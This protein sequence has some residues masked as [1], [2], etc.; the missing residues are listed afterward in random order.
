MKVK[1]YT[2]SFF[3]VCFFYLL[4][5]ISGKVEMA[6]WLKPILI[7]FL[8]TIISLSEK[9]KTQKLLQLGLFFSWIG[10]VLLLFTDRNSLF[11]ISGLVA[12]LIAHLVYIL[13]F[14]KQVKIVKS[15]QHIR[16]LPLIL[17]YLFGMI[18]LLWQ[19]LAEM[20]VPVI[21]YA[22]VISAMLLMSVKGYFEWKKPA[23]L[24]ILVGAILFVISDSILAI[25]KFYAPIPLSSFLIMSTY[26]A[27]QYFI[28]KGILN[29]NSV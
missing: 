19:S 17:V 9:F 12:F 16:I 14:Q 27:A 23:N 3:I 6:W 24:I 10:D 7:P 13:L 21:I 15:N 25:N 4:L 8:I 18:L 28:T 11:F 5:L 29:L 26:L 22:A 20:K 2:K 1:K